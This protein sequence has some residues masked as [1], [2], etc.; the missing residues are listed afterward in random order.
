MAEPRDQ[1]GLTRALSAVTRIL[2]ANHEHGSVSGPRSGRSAVVD[3]ALYVDG[4]REPGEWDYRA[5]LSAARR[6]SRAFVWLGL[7]EPGADE[8]SEIAHTF[9]LHEGVRDLAQ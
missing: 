6:R 8:L 1:R 4:A 7:H 2:G 3:C 9:G 5:A